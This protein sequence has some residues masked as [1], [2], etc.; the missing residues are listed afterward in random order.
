MKHP[1]LSTL[2]L[3][4][5][6]SLIGC[7][8]EGEGDLSSDLLE[9]SSETQPAQDGAKLGE[10][11]QQVAAWGYWGYGCSNDAWCYYDL[12]TLTDRTCFLVGVSGDY[13]DGYIKV[14]RYNSNWRLEMHAEANKS[15][16]A[17][18]VCISGD[19]NSISTTWIAGNPAKQILGTITSKRRCFL[20]G[21]SNAGT[22]ISSGLDNATD[23]IRTW[24]DSVGNWWV[25]GSIAGAATPYVYSTCVD[26]PAAYN[27]YGIVA[28]ASGTASFDMVENVAGDICGI[29]KFGGPLIGGASDGVNI[30]Y[31]G[32]T[33]FWNFSA[34]NG[35]F[36]EAL[37]VR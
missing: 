5:A 37:C 13:R 24:K 10:L 20:A 8:A 16:G 30:G 3:A 9:D 25:G 14:A 26:V 18:A 22:T 36:G 23:Y 15:I 4:S 32:G 33:H 35:K 29:T 28:P 11:D 31:D 19:T 2:A 27:P 17:R 34:Q 21:F 12:G 6:L 7:I 1:S